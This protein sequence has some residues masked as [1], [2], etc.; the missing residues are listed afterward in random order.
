ME[1]PSKN[2]FKLFLSCKYFYFSTLNSLALLNDI[3]HEQ[4]DTTFTK[5]A[6]IFCLEGSV[7]MLI[8]F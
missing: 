4:K 5:E 8:M 2:S 3:L 7:T 1:H 6:C